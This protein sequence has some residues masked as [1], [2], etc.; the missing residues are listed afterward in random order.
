MLVV[1]HDIVRAIEQALGPMRE[2]H[3]EK[4]RVRALTAAPFGMHDKV[5]DLEKARSGGSTNRRLSQD[6][7]K[8][9][10]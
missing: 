3:R 8:S 10:E 9:P 7:A 6:R 4:I 1:G 5:L 2:A